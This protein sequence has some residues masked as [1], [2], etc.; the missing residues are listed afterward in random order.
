MAQEGWD[1]GRQPAAAAVGAGLGAPGLHRG[2]GEAPRGFSL[3]PFSPLHCARGGVPTQGLP[4][5]AQS[6]G[7]LTP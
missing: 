2:P 6:R 4:P 7:S 5:F 1:S 3:S